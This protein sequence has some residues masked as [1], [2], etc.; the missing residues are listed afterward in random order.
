ML[1]PGSMLNASLHIVGVVSIWEA[2]SSRK[3]IFL[4]WQ[5]LK[6]GKDMVPIHPPE[7]T[8]PPLKG[9]CQS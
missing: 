4:L 1:I 2:F 8:V 6:E 7:D 3:G 5:S 9:Q